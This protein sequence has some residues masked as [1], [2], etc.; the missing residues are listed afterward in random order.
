MTPED[1]DMRHQN[2]CRGLFI[3]VNNK[4]NGVLVGTVSL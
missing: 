4:F 3:K 2:I 1:D